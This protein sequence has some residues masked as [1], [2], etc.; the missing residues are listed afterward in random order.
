VDDVAFVLDHLRLR[1]DRDRIGVAGHS[2]GGVTAGEAASQ[3]TRLRAVL[4]MAGTAGHGTM[5]ATIAPTLVIA[6]T[7][8]R[9]ETVQDSRTSE[10][11]IPPTIPRE[12]LVVEGARHG[13]LIGGCAQIGACE[14]VGRAATAF[15]LRYLAGAG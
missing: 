9:V 1:H 11:A 15:F 4:S 2:F 12:L 10:R 6:G 8:D 7:R 5:A 14:R 13:Q 3:D